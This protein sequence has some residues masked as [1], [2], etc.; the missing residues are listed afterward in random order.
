MGI[1]K[2]R[3][4]VDLS[5]VTQLDSGRARIW[6][7]AVSFLRPHLTT[8]QYC[9]EM[10]GKVESYSQYPRNGPQPRLS[11]WDS[12]PLVM[13]HF[14]SWRMNGQCSYFIF[15]LERRLHLLEKDSES[16]V[17]IS[18]VSAPWIKSD[19]KQITKPSPQILHLRIILRSNLFWRKSPIKMSASWKYSENDLMS[20]LGL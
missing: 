9:L 14:S 2:H 6:T 18:Q 3:E 16:T 7:Q 4:T 11:P 19:K 12:M 8:A 17:D 15:L 20:A 13:C 1:L 5:K 10:K